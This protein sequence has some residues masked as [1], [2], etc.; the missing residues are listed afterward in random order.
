MS[1]IIKSSF[2]I[3]NEVREA[4]KPEKPKIDYEKLAKEKSEKI[5]IGAQNKASDILAEAQEK[6]DSKLEQANKEAED[7]I[8]NANQKVEEVLADAMAKGQKDGY[9]TGY[10]EG[11]EI[12]DGLID[13]A[14]DIKR[15]IL[16][17]RKEYI[18]NLEPEI[19]NLVLNMCQAVLNKSLEE[20]KDL[21]MPIIYKG[22]E[23]LNLSDNLTIIVSDED[24]DIVNDSKNKILSRASLVEN[25]SIKIDR[26]FTK[27]DCT[28][29]SE[30]GTVNCSLDIQK[31]KLEEAI[32][33]LLK[34]E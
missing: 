11:K 4:K 24:Y 3:M 1:N 6:S 30:Y 5:L 32:I 21:I 10:N 8:N 31:K 20:D 26:K 16:K 29:E 2:V 17:T 27:G 9:Q 7:I 13:E 19:I 23:S 25:L 34:S 18:D 33:Q 12:S 22:L 15:E 28:I 14:N